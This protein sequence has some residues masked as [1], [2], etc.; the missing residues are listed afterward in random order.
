MESVST[1]AS[2]ICAKTISSNNVVIYGGYSKLYEQSFY[3]SGSKIITE[4]I[5]EVSPTTYAGT[6]V[7][8]AL[9]GESAFVSHRLNNYTG[10]I[11]CSSFDFTTS[12]ATTKIEGLTK[13]ACTTS[14][15]GEVWVLGTSQS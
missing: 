9:L 12:S 5:T 10:G 1:L 8:V 3:I 7:S 4:A 15:A 11:I 2:S 14:T 13:T 6:G